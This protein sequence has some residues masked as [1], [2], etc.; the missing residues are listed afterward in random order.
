VA[1]LRRNRWPLWIG[2]SGRNASEYAVTRTSVYKDN[3]RPLF[4]SD[5][6]SPDELGTYN[7]KIQIIETYVDALNHVTNYS[8]GRKGDY[9]SLIR[10]IA[11]AKKLGKRVGE[12]QAQEFFNGVVIFR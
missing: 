8:Q 3:P 6:C 11:Q 12:E 10:S 5:N 1:G 9:R 7:G 4:W 2:I